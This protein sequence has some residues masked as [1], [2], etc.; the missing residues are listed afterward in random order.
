MD[1]ITRLYEHQRK[2]VEKLSKVKVGALY[3]EMGTGKTRTALELINKRIEAGKVNKVIWLCPCSVKENLRRD[4][5][6]HTGEFDNDLITICGIETLSSSIK[7]NIKLL[8]L[9]KNNDCYLIVDESNLVKN[10]KAKRTERIIELSKLCTYKLILNGTPISKNEA[11]LF[12][13]WY[14]LDYRI[15]GYRSFWSFA[16]NH[17]EYDERI[18]GRVIKTLNVN[19][20]VEKIAPYSYQIRKDECLDLP[21]KSYDKVYFELTDDQREHY[22]WVADELIFELDEFD[23][24]TIYRLFTGL[25]HV[26]SG[27]KVDPGKKLTKTNFFEDPLNNPRMETLLNVVDSFG[28]YK[29]IIFAKYTDEIN[30]I[31]KVLNEKYGEGIA[32]PFNGEVSQKNRQENLVKFQNEARYLVANKNCGAYGLNLQFCS[33]IIYYSNDWDYATRSQS[34]DRVHRIG[35]NEHVDIVDICAAYTLDE[36][37]LKC[38]EKKEGLVDSFKDELEEIKDKKDLYAWIHNVK[39]RKNTREKCSELEDD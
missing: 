8:N 34:E 7:A 5:I 15:L 33:C 36:R 14:I 1:F 10:F 29:T 27:F 35:Q 21:V 13:Q 4:I 24:T 22:N 6:K 18:P 23:S 30:T 2:A 32:V 20:L 39:R 31:V 9:V 38:L 28:E 3:L 25:Q 11:D 12:A 16:A 37:I 17:L 26:T 19:Y